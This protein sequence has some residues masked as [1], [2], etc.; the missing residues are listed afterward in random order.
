MGVCSS[1]PSIACATR[2]VTVRAASS[3]GIRKACA[4]CRAPPNLGACTASGLS[5]GGRIV[6]DSESDESSPEDGSSCASAVKEQSTS[7]KRRRMGKSS[8]ASCVRGPLVIY[9][10]KTWLNK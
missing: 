8:Y 9:Q 2:V 3:I 7:R 10:G 6:E 5:E 4:R 1:T